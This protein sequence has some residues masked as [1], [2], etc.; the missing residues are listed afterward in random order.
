MHNLLRESIPHSKPVVEDFY[1]DEKMR[2][3][4][5]IH[6]EISKDYDWL[7]FDQY[8]ETIGSFILP[9]EVDVSD[10]RHNNIYG[11]V[12]KEET[13]ELSIVVYTVNF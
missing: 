4:V 8:G 1:V 3:W 11:S 6:K 9:E 7:V 13:G 2:V 12:E 10:I 5:N